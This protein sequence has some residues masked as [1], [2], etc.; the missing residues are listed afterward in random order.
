MSANIY[1]VLA[2]CQELCWVLYMDSHLIVYS[3]GQEEVRDL[4]QEHVAPSW[5][6]QDSD[7]TLWEPQPKA[8]LPSIMQEPGSGYPQPAF[9]GNKRTSISSST[10]LLGHVF[11]GKD[12]QGRTLGSWHQSPRPGP[13]LPSWG[14]TREVVDGSCLTHLTSHLPGES[15]AY[16]TRSSLQI[17]SLSKSACG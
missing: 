11:P 9:G 17:Y 14:C 3:G 10:W 2:V 4:S 13:A 15:L 8:V 12:P 16:N 5:Q 7:R 6:S 1:Q